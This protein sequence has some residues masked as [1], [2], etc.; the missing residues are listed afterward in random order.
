MHD[1][2]SASATTAESTGEHRANSAT[3]SEK[4]NE[5]QD[6]GD[7]VDPPDCDA[8]NDPP[9]G[10]EDR[11]SD[12]FAYR[13]ERVRLWRTVVTLAVVVARLIRSL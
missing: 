3:E 9:E 13:L 8:E 5:S 12:R 11:E 6:R 10:T 1:E 7:G 4:G 2:L